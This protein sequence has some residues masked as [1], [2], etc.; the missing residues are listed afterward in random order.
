LKNEDCKIDAKSMVNL[1]KRDVCLLSRSAFMEQDENMKDFTVQILS[2]IFFVA[3]E[4]SPK[5][6]MLNFSMNGG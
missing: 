3:T 1:R 5:F 6:D 4:A 2:G